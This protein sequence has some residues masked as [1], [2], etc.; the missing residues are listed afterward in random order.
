M[1]KKA[2]VILSGCG[3]KEGSEI[4]ETVLSYLAMAEGGIEY[5]SYAPHAYLA[6]S[7][8]IA[9]D[10]I[11][12]LSELQE[13][14][15]DILWLPGGMGVAKNLS[16]YAKDGPKCTVDKDVHRIIEAFRKGKKP[17]VAICFAPV[18]V[19][20]VL[21]GQGIQMTVGSKREDFHLLQD[22]GMKPV[23]CKADEICVDQNIYTAPGYMEPPSI[24]QIY[25]SLRK[26]I[27]RL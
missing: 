8:P 20:K 27:S 22:L 16:T 25:A 6:A 14:D 1:S 19:A 15:Y 23:P 21:E 13:K 26:V 24:A 18:I 3:Y 5:Y 7:A 11:A 17:I 9:R 4:H 12:P 2:A 10:K